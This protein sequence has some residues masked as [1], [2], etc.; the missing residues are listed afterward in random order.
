MQQHIQTEQQKTLIEKPNQRPQQPGGLEQ[1]RQHHLRHES[2]LNKE[3]V[4]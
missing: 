4:Q 3:Q 2:S 1:I